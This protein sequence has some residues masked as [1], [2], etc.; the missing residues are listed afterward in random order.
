MDNDN[1]WS[2]YFGNVEMSSTNYM[3]PD[4]VGVD[5]TL[6]SQINLGTQVATMTIHCII[7][8]ELNV[9]RVLTETNNVISEFVQ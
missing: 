8:Y 2:M 4:V 6:I 1:H 3:N 9:L 7:G 5:F